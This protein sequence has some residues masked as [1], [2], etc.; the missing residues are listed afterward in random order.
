MTMAAPLLRRAA[1]F[2]PDALRLDTAPC[3]RPGVLVGVTGPRAPWGRASRAGSTIAP[4]RSVDMVQFG[5]ADYS[6]SFGLAG[7]W[8][9]P[10][11]NEAENLGVKHFCM[12]WDVGI[13]LN[14]FQA[15]R[16]EAPRHDE[17]LS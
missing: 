6:M 8:D 11:L 10:R 1:V 7:Q 9:H 12:G 2:E 4:A 15:E 14:W 5:P 16:R 3:H 13:L 17:G